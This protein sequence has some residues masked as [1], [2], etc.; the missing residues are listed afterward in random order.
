[1]PVNPGNSIFNTNG[2]DEAMNG[3][4]GAD[5][6]AYRSYIAR[7]KITGELQNNIPLMLNRNSPNSDVVNFERPLTLPVGSWITRIDFR[8]PSRKREGFEKIYGLEIAGGTDIVGTT[9]EKLKVSFE[10][11][12]TNPTPA[13]AS[14]SSQYT[15]GSTA[16]LFRPPWLADQASPSL[17][18]QVTGGDGPLKLVVTNAG[19]TA[20]GT[21]IRLSTA[22][23]IAYV[24]VAVYVMEIGRAVTPWNHDLPPVPLNLNLDLSHSDHVNL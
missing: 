6:R 3:V 22:D 1:M 15:P 9:G 23:A 21:G 18:R 5:G 12:V 10:G 19:D 20:L 11:A 4:T 16:I 13:I 7:A 8:L 17:I 14:T 2:Y 24:Y